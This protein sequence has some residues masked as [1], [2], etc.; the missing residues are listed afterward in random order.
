MIY[1]YREIFEELEGFNEHFF[2]GEDL[3]FV[4]MLKK[5]SKQKGLKYRNI[6]KVKITTS[7]RRFNKMNFK[8]L[9]HFLVILLRPSL[10]KIKNNCKVLYSLTKR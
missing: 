8:D 7:A 3:L 4:R 1:I 10:M 5:L 9:I 6:Y 2:C